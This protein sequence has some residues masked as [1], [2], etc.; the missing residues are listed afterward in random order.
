MLAVRLRLQTGGQVVN[1]KPLYFEMA[2]T[3]ARLLMLNAEALHSGKWTREQ[4]EVAFAQIMR[5]AAQLTAEEPDY[6]KFVFVALAGLMF[7]DFIA[8]GGLKR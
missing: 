1:L 5:G 6:T 8:K 3:D 2:I 7:A 4:Y